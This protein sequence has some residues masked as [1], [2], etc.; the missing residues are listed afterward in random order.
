ML[1]DDNSIEGVRYVSTS[2]KLTM[3]STS[4]HQYI[5]LWNFPDVSVFISCSTKFP[6]LPLPFLDTPV[7]GGSFW[8]MICH[9][10]PITSWTASDS[11][12]WGQVR[13]YG[14]V[15]DGHPVLS[16]WVPH[17]W[18]PYLVSESPRSFR[19][20]FLTTSPLEKFC[21]LKWSETLGGLLWYHLYGC[22][23]I[24]LFGAYNLMLCILDGS[25]ITPFYWTYLKFYYELVVPTYLSVSVVSFSIP[26]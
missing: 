1:L 20:K 4:Y 25:V 13:V 8:Y 5:T 22:S 10:I 2:Y 14:T 24:S 23:T 11:L 12:S 19:Y 16:P 3:S 26:W 17:L 18:S 9:L 6:G 7:S 21:I 15:H